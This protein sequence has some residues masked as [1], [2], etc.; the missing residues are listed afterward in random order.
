MALIPLLESSPDVEIVAIHATQPEVA[1]ERFSSLGRAAGE[2]FSDRLVEDASALCDWPGL[3]VVIDAALETPF[4]ERFPDADE[5]LQVVSPLTA[6]LLWGYGPA[7]RE[8]QGELLQALREIVESVNLT[9]DGEHLFARVLEIAI[10]V[11]GADGGSIMLLDRE[12]QGLRLRAAVGVEPELWEKINVPLGHGIAGKVADDARPLRVRGKADPSQFRIVRERFDVEDALC[13]P[14]VH[15][16]TALGVLNLHH[17]SHRDA[18]SEGDLAFTDELAKASAQIIARAEEHRNLR[19]Q[20]RRYELVAEVRRCLSEGRPLEARMASLCDL[21]ARRLG[22]GIAN[23]YLAEPETNEL[24]LAATS[25]AGGAFLSEIRIGFGEG[26]DGR[27]AASRRPILMREEDGALAFVAL[28][29]LSAGDLVGVLSVQA[30]SRN[31][32]SAHLGPGRAAEETLQEIVAAAADEIAQAWRERR[33]ASRATKAGAINEAGIRLISA[34]ELSEV[35][36]LATASGALILEA[37]HA[38]LRLEDVE[39]G[40]YV[41]RSYYGSAERGDQEQ[42][43]GLDKQVSVR[44][45]RDRSP[46]LVHRLGQDDDFDPGDSGVRSILAAPLLHEGRVLGTLCMYDKMAPDQFYPGHFASDDLDVLT[47]Y[48]RYV[49]RA[50]SNAIYYGRSRAQ[51][52]F[53]ESTGLPNAEYLIR[54]IDQEITRARGRVDAFIIATCRIENLSELRGASDAAHAERVVQ[55]TAESLREHLRDFDV[56]ARTGD[57]EFTALI[58]DP[59]PLPD[60]SISDLARAIAEDVVKDV[61]LNRPTRVNLVFGHAM[62]SRPDEGREAVIQRS[63]E[64][65]IRMI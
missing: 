20:A 43:F 34:R 41:I 9:V 65:R 15:E 1:R 11:L 37:D 18:F 25:L 5:N 40:R 24:R 51:N 56:L 10:G 27:A 48:A 63:R 23:L 2:R 38:V 6:R 36:R 32:G 64:P 17:S 33:M 55:R 7:A 16:G 62:R 3:S 61:E 31:P 12:R 13:V 49:E 53:D 54:R 47:R 30:G 59:G 57:D 19:R 21:L 14:L 29:M 8:R 22:G 35:S 26:L 45:L 28:P 44:V 52:N 39:S 42:L 46:L 50:V 4:R 58:P 60:D